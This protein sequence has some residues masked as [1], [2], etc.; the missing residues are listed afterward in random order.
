MRNDALLDQKLFSHLDIVIDSE[1]VSVN[2]DISHHD[3]TLINI[4]IHCLQKRSYMRKG[5][6]HK[7]ADLNK[8][9]H[10][11]LEFKWGQY[12]HECT[13][14]DEMYNRVTPKYLE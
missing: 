14:A 2:M 6:I 11:L 9:N 7:N 10:E 3:A 13:N 8:Q 12:L 1:V 4:K 5:W